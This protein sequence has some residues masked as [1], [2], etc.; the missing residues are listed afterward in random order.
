L[1]P[2]VLTA[3]GLVKR[4]GNFT[5]VA[6]VDLTVRAGEIFGLLG[7]NGAGK[8]TTVSMCTGLLSP[9]SGTVHVAGYDITKQAR[10]AKRLIGYVPDEPY[11]YEKLTGREFVHFMGQIYGVRDNLPSR[12]DNLLAYFGLTDAADNLVGGY[13]HGMKQKVGL[14]ATLIHDPLL[15]VLDEPTVGLDPKGARLLKDTLQALAGRGRAVIL[16]THIMEIAQAICDRVAILDA[17]SIVAHGTIH[18][19]RGA[20]L[21]GSNASLEEIF[22]Q[23]TGDE[24]DQDVVRAL[25]V[26]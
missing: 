15:L 16:C 24:G 13:S 8:T 19:L 3:R 6:G 25:A 20:V 17:G 12:A 2:D 26:P 18:E 23:L 14:C 22:L 11:I 9:T 10:A 21:G 1:S 5:A 4:Y 7:P